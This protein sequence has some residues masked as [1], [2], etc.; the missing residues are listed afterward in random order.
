[1]K[2]KNISSDLPDDLTNLPVMHQRKSCVKC[3]LLPTFG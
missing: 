3:Y 2:W 1:M